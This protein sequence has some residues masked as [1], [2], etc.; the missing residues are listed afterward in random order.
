MYEINSKNKDSRPAAKATST[1]HPL[2]IILGTALPFVVND[3]QTANREPFSLPFRLDYAINDGVVSIRMNW[4]KLKEKHPV[5][6]AVNF[7][8]KDGMEEVENND[9]KV[10]IWYFTKPQRYSGGFKRSAS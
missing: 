2:P 6:K 9:E 1:R 5:L 4:N 7:E 3:A 10:T 8:R